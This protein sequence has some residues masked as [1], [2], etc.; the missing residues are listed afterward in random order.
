MASFSVAIM[1]AMGF[2]EEVRAG[3]LVA[4]FMSVTVYEVRGVVMPKGYAKASQSR[5]NGVEY[6]VALAE[7]VNDG[8]QAIIGDDFDESEESWRKTVQSNGPFA[9][10]GVGP[11][12]F[13]PC[14]AGRVMR[15]PNGG[16]ITYDLFSEQRK[17]LRELECR[18]LPPISV[19][20]S[21]ALGGKLDRTISLRKLARVSEGRTA[22]EV[23]IHDIRMDV[24]LEAHASHPLESNALSESL[25]V[26]ARRA[27]S[28]NS[29]AAKFFW[30]AASEEDQLKRFLYFFLA[31]EIQTHATFKRL[32][33][34]KALTNFLHPSKQSR[35]NPLVLIHDQIASLVNLLDRF[36]WCAACVWR[37]L[38]ESDVGRFR[39]LKKARDRIAHGETS[40]PPEGFALS[41]Q[42][43]A[44]KVLWG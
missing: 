5:M 37:H 38:S 7:S 35:P 36:V 20:L 39:E 32:D 33:H 3:D 15:N 31:M 22:D 42:L 24:R 1:E 40:K 23:R 19:A 8:C 16:L 43:L 14:S 25:A 13:L 44:Q 9:L 11:T 6:R 17:T 34:E 21:C 12:E 26:A 41:A 29:R 10:V 18:V 30:L 2:R 4:S 28:L 27:P